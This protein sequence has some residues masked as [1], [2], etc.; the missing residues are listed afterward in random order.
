MLHEERVSEDISIECIA[1]NKRQ[2]LL[3]CDSTPKFYVVV[4]SYELGT[5]FASYKVEIGVLKPDGKTVHISHHYTRYS[6][7][8]QL[9]VESKCTCDFPEKTWFR[10]GNCAT[11]AEYRVNKFNDFFKYLTQIKDVSTLHSFIDIFGK[12]ND[13]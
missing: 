4:L 9:Y 1:T 10:S 7:V 11:V 13:N 8:L 6:K 5:S 3:N 12:I 2:L